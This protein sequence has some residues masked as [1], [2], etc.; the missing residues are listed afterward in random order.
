MANV[1]LANG[2]ERV[3]GGWFNLSLRVTRNVAIEN[4]AAVPKG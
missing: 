4:H 2:I 3:G 1:E